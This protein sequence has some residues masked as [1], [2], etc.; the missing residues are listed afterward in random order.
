MAYTTLNEV[1]KQ[2]KI[3]ESFEKDMNNKKI[4]C[5]ALK[6][7]ILKQVLKK[8]DQTTLFLSRR[9]YQCSLKI[10]LIGGKAVLF[11]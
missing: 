3:R 2:H 11:Y 5:D 4:Q 9:W 8:F 1:F 10:C 6:R 7:S